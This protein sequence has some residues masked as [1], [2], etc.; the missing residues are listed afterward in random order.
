MIPDPPTAVACRSCGSRELEIILSLGEQPL[1]NALR[2]VAD[3]DVPELR[4]PLDVAFCTACSLVQLTVTVPPSILFEQYPYFS[5]YSD[6]V[7]ANARDLVERLVGEYALDGSALAME[8]ASNDGYLLQHYQRCGVPV[9]GVDPAENVVA[10]ARANGVPTRCEFFDLALATE[11]RDADQRASTLHA[12]NVL[13]HVPEVASVVQGIARVLR[14]D[15][16]AVIETPYVRDL[17]DRVEFDT[18]YHEHL[19]YYSVTSLARLFAANGLEVAAVE[20]IPIHGG[21]LRVFAQLPGAAAPDPS[22]AAILD[23]EASL[24]I[25]SASY[26]RDFAS[27]VDALLAELRELLADL[28]A[29]GRRIAGYGAAAKA[30]VLLNA[31]GVGAETIEFV[32][33][34]SPH[35]QGRLIPGTT[36]PIE[37]AERLLEEGPDDT[38]LFSWNFADEVLAQQGEY[39]AR[40]GRF[41]IPIPTPR[42]V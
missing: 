22:V 42:V 17:V 13:A 7:V 23:E 1:A 35:K 31:L 2:P 12:N 32:A 26:Y 21:S 8:I 10:V 11:L 40:G 18:I 36:I 41:L 5:S 29:Q 30:T 28:R 3:A 37:P 15:G 6:T 34:R 14:R 19:F 38:V 33:D 9:L 25:D 39:R 4:F 24:G 20:R 16:R 27:R